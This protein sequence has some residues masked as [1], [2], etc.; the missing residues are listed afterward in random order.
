MTIYI[1]LKKLTM[2]YVSVN[3]CITSKH[4]VCSIFLLNLEYTYCAKYFKIFLC[5]SIAKIKLYLRWL[6]WTKLENTPVFVCAWHF[7][8][9]IYMK[10]LSWQKCFPPSF[11][12]VIASVLNL[13]SHTIYFDQYIVI[14]AYFSYLKIVEELI[15]FDNITFMS[16]V[17]CIYEQKLLLVF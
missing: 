14:Y 7:H 12:W 11:L 5:I 9:T 13:I 2:H 6:K 3:I 4:L 10:R 15:F 16:Y 17:W 1:F 8:F